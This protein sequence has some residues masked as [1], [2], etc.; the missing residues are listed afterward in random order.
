MRIEVHVLQNFAPSNLNRD[1]TG[2]PKD[3][4]FGGYRRARVSS[5]CLKRAVRGY[6]KDEKLFDKTQLGERTKRLAQAVAERLIKK[7]RP[8]EESGRA[9]KTAVSA[10]LPKSEDKD[11]HK[12]PYLLFLGETEIGRFVDEVDRHWE[13]FSAVPAPAADD[14]AAEAPRSRGRGRQRPAE[15]P[16]VPDGFARA[17]EKLLDGG[18][19]ADLALFGRMLADLPDNNVDA[20]CQVAH[21]IST[22]KI[23]SMEMDYYTAVDDLKPGDTAGADMIG[24]VE[25]NSA[26]F[27][28]Y[29]NLDVDQLAQN[30]QGDGELSRKTAEAFLRAFVHAIPTG[31]QNTFAAQNLPSLV[32]VTV[33]TGGPVSLTN[34]FV[35]PVSPRT[36]GNLVKMSIE[37]LDDYYG[38][39]VK[40]YGSGGL[41]RSAV[42]QLDGV[43]LKHLKEDKD[44]VDEVIASTITAA[45][46]VGG[47]A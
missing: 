37:A 42:C 19:A 5:Q 24:T 28:R 26:C 1:D 7:G 17:V 46:S 30:L 25:F 4:E 21:S 47:A 8:G 39:V 18:K 2:S 38:R 31:K 9:A 43:P 13:A 10:F 3:A 36:G 40:M 41:R 20:A 34:A 33:S 16:K 14:T 27:Y 15:G 32:F 23:H 45:F 22:N 6:F 29:A 44:S 35:E 11:E 12:T